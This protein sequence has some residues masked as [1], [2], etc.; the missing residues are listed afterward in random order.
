MDLRSSQRYRVL[1]PSPCMCVCVCVCLCSDSAC[2]G[3]SARKKQ[4]GRKELASSSLRP[5]ISLKTY[6]NQKGRRCNSCRLNSFIRKSRTNPGRT[7][8]TSLFPLRT[9]Q[10]Q[11]ADA[12]QNVEGLKGHTPVDKGNGPNT[13][14]RQNSKSPDFQRRQHRI[15]LWCL[16]TV[17]VSFRGPG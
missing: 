11:N 9:L 14:P 15:A 2:V 4:E 10:M 3:I 12:L 6:Q 7:P 13:V 1:C 5:P 16:S 8:L 17:W